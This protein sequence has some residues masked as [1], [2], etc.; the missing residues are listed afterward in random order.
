MT[1]VLAAI[2]LLLLVFAVWRMF[3]HISRQYR[4]LDDGDIED[5]L[6]NRLEDNDL[7]VAR[8][9][10]LFCEACKARMDELSSGAVKMKPGRWM[11]RRF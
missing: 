5:L 7:K 8:E 10:I 4:H 1:Q 2:A 6:A 3:K 11:K 9:H